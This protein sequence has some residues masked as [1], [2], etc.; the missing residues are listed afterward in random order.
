MHLTCGEPFVSGPVITMLAVRIALW[1]QA[2]LIESKRQP[3]PGTLLNY[4]QF[5]V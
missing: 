4:P 2:F 3:F 5:H 1:D